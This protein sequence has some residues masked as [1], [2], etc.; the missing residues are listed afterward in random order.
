MTRS[1]A[2]LSL[3]LWLAGLGGTVAA[4]DGSGSSGAGG[5]GGDTTGTG[6]TGA[7]G[8]TG[9]TGGGGGAATGGGAI[10]YPDSVLCPHPPATDPRCGPAFDPDNPLDEE[11]LSKALEEGLLAWR[12]AGTDGACVGCHSPDAY[13]LAKVGY[14]DEDIQRRAKSH[15]DQQKA[16]AL[17]AFVHALRQ[18]H[19]MTELLHPA[20]YRPEQPAFE[21]F[22]ETTPGLE[23]TDSQAQDERDEAF[24][25]ALTDDLGLLW[26]TGK[27]DSLEKA[28]KARDELLAVDLRTQKLGIPFDHLSEDGWHG[29]PHR[30][31]FEWY[32]A[33]ASAPLAGKEAEWFALEDAY[34]AD[35][36]DANFWAYYDAIDSLT[37]C[38]YD[39]S[40]NGDPDFY[41]PACDWMRL[42]FKSL[43]VAQHMLRAS[44]TDYPDVLAGTPAG[45]TKVQALDLVIARSPIWEAGDLL[46]VSPLQR[47]QQTACFSAPNLPCTLLPEKIDATVHEVPTYEEA[48]I[49]QGQVFQQSWFVMSWLRDPALL[50][51]SHN[52]AT[53]I[54]D[55]L[56]SVLLPHY[57]IHHAF[58]VAR[59]AAEKSA[60]T[61]WMD[62][63]G[64][65][66]GTGKIASVRTFSFKQIRNNFSPPPDDDPRRATHERMFANFA[67]MWIYLVDDDLKNSAEIF[68]RDEVLHAVRFMRTWIGELEGAEDPAINAVVLSIEALA[69]A[70]E[71]LRTQQNIDEN[72]GTGL[73]P[74]GTWGEFAA[75]YA[76]N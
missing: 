76:G 12:F 24:M 29:E 23:V 54:G 17:V 72:P 55:Y 37:D 22:A 63:G 44:T 48:R 40:G 4:C 51:E 38:A 60:V 64:F 42:K 41:R 10:V 30:S 15:V 67:R 7:T 16:D 65:R 14:S 61:G 27:V 9:A 31:I 52:F 35:P 26:A 6:G 11:A 75:P 66:A 34:L 5:Q 73:Q 47:P 2:R 68:D 13:D 20:K 71:E 58:V 53:F 28:V 57:D 74:T 45:T 3:L 50:H 39:L 33:M 59:M 25:D 70:A 18:K 62:A 46:R 36:S 43:Q 21:A 56:E 1:F 69:P 32:P 8:A 49:L 19:G